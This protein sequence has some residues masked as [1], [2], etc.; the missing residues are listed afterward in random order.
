MNRVEL[1]TVLSDELQGVGLDELEGVPWLRSYVHADDLVEA[2]MTVSHS[3]ATS[4]AEQIQEPPHS[5]FPPCLYS[6][7]RLYSIFASMAASRSMP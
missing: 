5:A 2:G 4:S 6:R 7:V 3:S 1:M